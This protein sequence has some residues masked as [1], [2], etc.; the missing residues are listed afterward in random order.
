MDWSLT[1]WELGLV[2]GL[3]LLAGGTLAALVNREQLAAQP[4]P[5][6]PRGKKHA[7]EDDR[8]TDPQ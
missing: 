1:G 6:Q 8:Q 2:T 3:A 4:V 7:A 5:V